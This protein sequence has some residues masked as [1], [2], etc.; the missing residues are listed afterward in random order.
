MLREDFRFLITPSESF[1][2]RFFKNQNG[3][4][5][6]LLGFRRSKFRVSGF[7]FCFCFSGIWV[8]ASVFCLVVA[9]F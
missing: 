5:Q 6:S 7:F 4:V 2:S 3:F 1:L 8:S 9:V